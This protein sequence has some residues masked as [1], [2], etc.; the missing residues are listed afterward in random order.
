MRQLLMIPLLLVLFAV[1]AL[2]GVRVVED[3][4]EFRY[5]DPSAATVHLAGAF[6]DW[7]T[8][9]TPLTDTD[10][11]GTWTTVLQLDPGSY[12]YKFVVNG[13]TW[14]A[15]P[16][17]PVTGGDYGNSI[18]E[19]MPDGSIGGT[20]AAAPRL[21][22]GTP[23]RS[24]TPLH[25]RV[26]LGGFFRLIQEGTSNQPGDD[27]L[28][29]DRPDDQF[30][31]DVT[32][33]LNEDVWGSARLQVRTDTGGFNEIGTQ[34]YKAQANFA[35]ENFTVRA[36]YNEE[37][38]RSGDPLQLL[39][40]GRPRGIHDG[41]TRA[42]GQ[43]RQG[44]VLDLDPFGTELSIL[45]ADTY[46]EDVLGPT[47][48]NENTGTDYLL[49]RWQH[50]IGAGRVGL[51]YRGIY[52]DWWINFNT[53][54]VPTVIEEHWARQTDRDEDLRSDWF[55]AANDEHFAALDVQWPLLEGLDLTLAGGAGLYD[56]RYDQ[57]NRE[58]VQ[59]SSLTNGSVDLPIGDRDLARG[60]AAVRYDRDHLSLHAS[61]ELWWGEGM[62]AD[63]NS[64]RYR[65]QAG[66]IVE[67]FDRPA[68][69][70]PVTSYVAP[71]DNQDL[72]VLLLGPAPEETMHRTV[73][74]GSYRWE[75]FEFGLDWTREKEDFD[76]ADFAESGPAAFERWKFEAM[77]YVRYRPF[78]DPAQY[79]ALRARTL[80]YS[81]PAELEAIDLVSA[82][83]TGALYGYSDF[84]RLEKTELVLDGRVPLADLLPYDL[85]MR[86]DLRWIDYRDD[87]DLGLDVVTPEGNVLRAVRADQSFFQPFAALVYAPTDNVEIEVGYG[88]DPRYYDVISPEGWENGR[89]QF[90]EQYVRSQFGP[91]G[92]A[93]DFGANPY[94]DLY[95]LLGDEEIEDQNRFIINALVKF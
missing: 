20:P 2:A 9:A 74:G 75:Q 56:A 48:Q 1:P 17:N 39:G 33:N 81:D 27:R 84:L 28:R 53:N 11:D 87:E 40:Y 64:L 37:I 60:K 19:L 82:N 91:G 49:A 30:N 72:A 76:Y 29:T 10:G 6:N 73:L 7:S 35:G 79:L 34:L 71:N 69:N 57:G 42:F 18:L 90:R 54:P 70:V 66:S 55:E 15:D 8:T 59:G 12:E 26:Y 95:Q 63:E 68:R 62:D 31:L 41:S 89:Y 85:D 44:V 38:F 32:A 67:D 78:E 21:P 65:T 5:T 16:D 51:T 77:P 43:G 58:E 47:D 24:N 93:E 86:F 4:V 88:V 92:E 45:Y 52:S 80:D 25:S 83:T 14:V 23:A 94:S 36:F 13:G 22:S 50:R 46:D 3:G 61:H